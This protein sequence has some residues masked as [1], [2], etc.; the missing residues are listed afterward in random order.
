[1][2]SQLPHK[3]HRVSMDFWSFCN[4]RFKSGM[5]SSCKRL[6]LFAVP[7]WLRKRSRKPTTSSTSTQTYPA[8]PTF[9]LSRRDKP[10]NLQVPPSPATDPAFEVLLL[11]LLWASITCQALS[12]NSF[13]SGLTMLQ[14]GCYYPILQV[15]P[16]R[17]RGLPIKG[18]KQ[19]SKQV[20]H[21]S[22]L[23]SEALALVSVRLCQDA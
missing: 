3:A 16:L 7:D 15:K 4:Y 2:A 14:G 20:W 23:P 13:L 21:K 11:V 12:H 1:M 8:L 6:W 18:W 22:P 19:A 9:V 5:D 10:G 17:T